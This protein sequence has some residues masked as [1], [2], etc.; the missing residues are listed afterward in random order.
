MLFDC[1]GFD[2]RVVA[3]AVVVSA[4]PHHKVARGIRGFLHHKLLARYFSNVQCLFALHRRIRAEKKWSAGE[5]QR[6]FP[7]PPPRLPKF[8][9]CRTAPHPFPSYT[10]PQAQ[11]EPPPPL[12]AALVR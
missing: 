2:D 4:K 6:N 9:D 7:C 12:P 11:R 1:L 5:K 10:A 8:A 3:L